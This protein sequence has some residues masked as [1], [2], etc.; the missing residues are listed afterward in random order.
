MDEQKLL[1]DDLRTILAIARAQSLS[2]AARHLGVSHATVFRRL[3][4]IEERLGVKL[5]E[6]SRSGYAP[7]P[8]GEDVVEAAKRMDTEV[9]NIE[10]R[11]AGRDLLPSGTVRVTTTDVLLDGVLSPVFAEFRR[12][13]PEIFLEV[14]VS[15]VLFS[16]SKR[17]ADVAIRP[18]RSPPENLVGRR[19]GSL[20]QAVY[21]SAF[22]YPG[23]GHA[24]GLDD[25]EWVG[26][27]ERMAYVQLE[28]WMKTRVPDERCRYRVD[29]L[30][31]M[32]AGVRDGL[33]VAVLPC[34]L[35]DSDG[36]LVRLS[37]VIPELATDLWLLT[38]P[39]LRRV[40]RIRAF[41]EFV[42]NSVRGM[43]RTLSGVR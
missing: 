23:T 41:T 29:T 3:G 14:A 9:T 21:G 26:P 2:G 28:T 30:Q 42:A 40:A 22:R 35:G 39:D 4:A 8:A 33:G 11:V 6:R 34:Y 18:T 13:H 38:H 31:G 15:N 27:D 36:R 5:F 19:I 37:G 12:S 17:E 25:V 32:R 1:W 16:L 10:R 43:E 24:P 7:T 20:A